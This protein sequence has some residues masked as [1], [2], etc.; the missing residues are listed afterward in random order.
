[1]TARPPPL[2]A[3][4][5]PPLPGLCSQPG[6]DLSRYSRLATELQK[7]GGALFALE[8]AC[9]KGR[10]EQL[11]SM[12]AGVSGDSQV[13]KVWLALCGALAAA[14]AACAGCAEALGHLPLCGACSGEDGGAG[15]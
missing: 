6:A 15:R 7:L 8:G 11:F 10:L 14:A 1:M 9:S 12:P 3:A 13:E 5:E 2:Q 4:F